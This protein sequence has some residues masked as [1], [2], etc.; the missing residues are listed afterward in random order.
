MGA[1]GRGLREGI[2][3]VGIMWRGAWHPPGRV[4]AKGLQH[5]ECLSLKGRI[6]FL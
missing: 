3:R 4:F 2:G 5:V 6:F 1:V